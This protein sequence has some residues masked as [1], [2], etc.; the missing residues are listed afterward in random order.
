MLGTSHETGAFLC[1]ALA[2][3]W[4]W[5]GRFRYP[6]AQELLLTFDAG[7]PSGVHSTR[8][9]EDL[10]AL[11]QRVGLRLRIA[12]YPPYTSKWHPI[13]HRLF[14][15][16]E[17]ALQGIIPDSLETVLTAIR[18]TTT[19]TGLRGKAYLLEKVYPL[20]RKC[21]AAFATLKDQYIR[22]ED[23]LGPWNYTVDAVGV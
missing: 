15:Q 5:Y 12:P 22:H 20:K 21:S 23:F 2:R 9:K 6:E 13:E 14:S 8:F 19:Q 4:Q 7:G 18:R 17:R 1:D 10:L 11:S 3:C 16:V